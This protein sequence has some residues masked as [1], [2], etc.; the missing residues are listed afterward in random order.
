MEEDNIRPPD[1][2][3]MMTLLG[4]NDNNNKNKKNK[5]KNKIN[6]LSDYDRAVK[7]SLEDFAD[8]DLEQILLQSQ[9]EFELM[10]QIKEI[11][12][13][14][15]LEREEKERKELEKNIRAISYET[16]IPKIKKM[17]NFDKPNEET[18]KLLLSVINYYIEGKSIKLT[19]PDNILNN[20]FQVL[21]GI[22]LTN[23]E[24]SNIKNLFV[25]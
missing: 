13:I 19:L 18:Y 16:V 8:K 4:N 6:I 5:N 21:K 2:A 11:E 22:R 7:Q 12:E 3:K 20:I 15:R 17:E 23:E 9:E 24:L 14:E 10:Q 25:I 1:E